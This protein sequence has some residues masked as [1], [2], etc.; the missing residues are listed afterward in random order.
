MVRVSEIAEKK[1]MTEKVLMTTRSK[2]FFGALTVVT[3]SAVAAHTSSFLISDTR[4][5]HGSASGPGGQIPPG[6]QLFCKN[7]AEK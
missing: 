4:R 3:H 7:K 5:L 1:Q 6:P 2:M